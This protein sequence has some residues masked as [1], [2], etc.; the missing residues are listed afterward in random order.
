M[1]QVLQVIV[2]SVFDRTILAVRR[3]SG[4]PLS[5]LVWILANVHIGDTI[6]SIRGCSSGSLCQ[7]HRSR[8]VYIAGLH[9]GF[10]S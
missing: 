9:F 3:Q 7:D 8:R 10:A 1:P 6:L 2:R 4:G 5:A